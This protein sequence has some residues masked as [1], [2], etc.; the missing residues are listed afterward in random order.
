[1]RI[2]IPHDR[3]PVQLGK[4]KFNL[5]SHS[6]EVYVATNE[7]LRLIGVDVR[8]LATKGKSPITK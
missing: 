1:L 2:G 3:E 4:F 8:W 6:Q 7:G 5:L